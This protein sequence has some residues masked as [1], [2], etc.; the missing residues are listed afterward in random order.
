MKF[1]PDFG[2]ARHDPHNGDRAMPRLHLRPCG[3]ARHDRYLFRAMAGHAP[4]GT[5]LAGLWLA[6]P[7]GLV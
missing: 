7:V 4:E 3:P 2:P 6:Q 5:S 1:N